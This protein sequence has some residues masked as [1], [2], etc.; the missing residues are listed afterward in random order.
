MAQQ[1]P[2]SR[3]CHYK[4]GGSN[5][6]RGRGQRPQIQRQGFT[7]LPF[8]GKRPSSYVNPYQKPKKR[9]REEQGD[10]ALRTTPVTV[11]ATNEV[12]NSTIVYYQWDCFP[13]ISTTQFKAGRLKDFAHNWR[14]W[15]LMPLFLTQF[16]TVTLS[17]NKD[18]P[19]TSIM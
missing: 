19:V 1:S 15:P 9:G 6:F 14:S 3:Q 4:S 17:L 12:R 13:L 18:P 7:Q 16:N 5:K 11:Q 2:Y 8:L 10:K